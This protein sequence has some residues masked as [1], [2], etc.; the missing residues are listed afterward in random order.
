MSLLSSAKARGWH[1]Y[2][3]PFTSWENPTALGTPPPPSFVAH[4]KNLS[5][6]SAP[7]TNYI[8]FWLTD[9]GLGGDS[10]RARDKFLLQ[11]GKVLS[12][13]LS[14]HTVWDHS[15]PF[16]AREEGLIGIYRFTQSS[17]IPVMCVVTRTHKCTYIYTHVCTQAHTHIHIC[18]HAHAHT[19]QT[20]FKDYLLLTF[21]VVAYVKLPNLTAMSPLLT[22]LEERE[23]TD[24]VD[25]PG[26]PII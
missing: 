24:F 5:P 13:S 21:S 15:A 8:T 25:I 14:K 1:R 12:N 11:G 6:P 16:V 7:G 3:C 26:Q 4:N 20:E 18:T 19:H 10:R 22:D 23:K 9:K 17:H 2:C